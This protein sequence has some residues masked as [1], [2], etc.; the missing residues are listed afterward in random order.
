M[1]YYIGSPSQ[2]RETRKRKATGN[3]KEETK[4]PVFTV[5]LADYTENRKFNKRVQ[6]KWLARSYPTLCHPMDCIVHEILQER[7]LEWVA[8]AFSRGSS[9]PRDGTRVCCIAGKFFTVWATREAPPHCELLL[10]LSVLSW[11]FSNDI[12]DRNNYNITFFFSILFHELFSITTTLP[13]FLEPLFMSDS[14]HLSPI[15]F[16]WITSNFPYR[17]R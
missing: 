12:S 11:W 3:K 8:I 13:K 14:R 5:N 10:I 9:R 4:K 2:Q 16:V 6:Q 7:I 1:H 17:E 15:S